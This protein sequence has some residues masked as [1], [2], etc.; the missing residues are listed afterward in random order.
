MVGPG[1]DTSRLEATELKEKV[2][3]VLCILARGTT[4]VP[5]G[6]LGEGGLSHGRPA[7]TSRNG[8]LGVMAM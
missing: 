1:A 7:H 8:P 2:A 5:V 3:W 4:V 6:H